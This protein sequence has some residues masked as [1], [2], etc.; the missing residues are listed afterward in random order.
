[1][2]APTR[3]RAASGDGKAYPKNLPSLS[4]LMARLGD[5]MGEAGGSS[6]GQGRSHS[7]RK[8]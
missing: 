4:L 8:W 3:V 5:G 1:M 6:D 2:V 7:L